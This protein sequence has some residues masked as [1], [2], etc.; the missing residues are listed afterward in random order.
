MTLIGEVGYDRATVEAI[1]HRAGV[2]KPTIYRRWPGGKQEI[3]VEALRTK[4]AECGEL[5][6]TGTL[7]G[8]LMAMLD[9]VM[10]SVDAQLAGG[11]MSHLRASDELAD[12]FRNE[13]VADERRATTS[14]SSARTPATRSP[15]SPPRCSPTSPAP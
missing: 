11:L 10:L 8:D 12:L 5:P 3:V 14:C 15:P 7:R 6:D 1:A 4:R 2:S 9:A 13:V